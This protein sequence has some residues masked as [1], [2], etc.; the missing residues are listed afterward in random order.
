MSTATHETV[1]QHVVLVLGREQYAV[2]IFQTREIVRWSQPRPVPGQPE[3]VEGALDLRGEL[4]TVVDLGK[5]LGVPCDP[6]PDH[7]DIVVVENEGARPL[8]LAVDGVLDVLDSTPDQ[9]RPAPEGVGCAD[10]V[11]GIIVLDDRLVV[12]LDVSKLFRD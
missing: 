9:H 3:D 8:G 7:R 4:V 11:N 10:H 12:S 1:L 5:R 6:N 2:P